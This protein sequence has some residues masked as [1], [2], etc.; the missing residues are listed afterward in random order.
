MV[1]CDDAKCRLVRKHFSLAQC[2]DMQLASRNR[3]TASPIAMESDFVAMVALKSGQ[4]R[5]RSHIALRPFIP[6][7]TQLLEVAGSLPRIS[8]SV[9]L[10]NCIKVYA[11]KMNG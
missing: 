8:L 1:T 9:N 2:L 11:A 3:D 10:I 6:P 5:L 7:L 4:V